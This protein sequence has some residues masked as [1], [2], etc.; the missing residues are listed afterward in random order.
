MT[1]PAAVLALVP[2]LLLAAP[3]GARAGE[4]A[5]KSGTGSIP[6]K[7]E[8]LAKF[9]WG[10]LFEPG[11]GWKKAPQVFVWNNDA[12]PETLDPALMTGVTEGNVALA[13]FEGLTTHHPASLHPLPGVASWWE[14]S[15]DGLVYTFH[16]RKEA[17][18]SNGDPV[19]AEDFR[20]SWERALTPATGCKYAEMFF[21]V[22]GAEDFYAGKLRSFAEVGVQVA[23]PQTLRVTLHSPTAYFTEICAFHTLMPVHRATV[24]RHGDQW[25]AEGKIVGNGPFA[26]T[27]WKKNDRIEVVPN[28][29]WWNRRIVRLERMVIR[30]IADLNTSFKEYLSGGVDWIRQIGASSV[31]EAQA[32][33]DYYVSPY[34]GSYFFRFNVT[35]E[36]FDDVRVRRAMSQAID[37]RAICE[38]VLKAGQVPATGVVA[39]GIEGYPE[40]KGH[41]YDP[42]RA[43]EL[44]AEAGFP[45]GK[46]FPEIELLYNT[47]ESHKQVCEQMVEMWKTVLGIRVRLENRE[48]QVYLKDTHSMN[49]QI[50]RGA[51]IADYA[52]PSTFLDMWVTDRGNN[53]TGWSNPRYDALLAAAAKE[54]DPE[55]RFGILQKAEAILCG[56]DLPILPVYYYVNQGMLRP[57]VRGWHENVRDHHPF[58]YVWIDGAAGK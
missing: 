22:R 11:D 28:P 19:T 49:Y 1:R 27:A 41:D 8:A 10:S 34:L 5:E 38:K 30:A 55:K 36:P 54:A 50:V 56:E 6:R 17:R 15:D 20:W 53:N 58:Q 42:K 57:R 46:G 25:T 32:H 43:R 7:G 37:R 45:E 33:P 39:L 3:S 2:V 16:L 21:A 52:D 40:F 9:D 23:D 48:W 26:L 44:L 13:L 14:I 29:H 24:E 4:D 18:W 12:E 47:H 31:E 35:K 51:W